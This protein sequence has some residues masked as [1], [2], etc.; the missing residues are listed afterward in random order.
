[1]QTKPSDD[2]A[3]AQELAQALAEGSLSPDDLAQVIGLEDDPEQERR[4]AEHRRARVGALGSRLYSMAS[5]QVQQR[6]QVT[7]A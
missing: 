3:L 4:E 1:M 6:Q 7:A 5:E 2:D